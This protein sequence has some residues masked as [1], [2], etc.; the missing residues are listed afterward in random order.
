M[1]DILNDYIQNTLLDS[2]PPAFAFIN[3]EKYGK[4]S[5]EKIAEKLNREVEKDSVPFI[6]SIIKNIVVE[7]NKLKIIFN[8]VSD[9]EIEAFITSFYGNEAAMEDILKKRMR[10]ILLDIFSCK[11]LPVI[12]FVKAKKVFNDYNPYEDFAERWKLMDWYCL[13]YCKFLVKTYG[14]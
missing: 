13:C 4:G 6:R 11:I 5:I 12:E 10:D 1:K 14:M 7:G 8:N 2:T 9:V 3:P